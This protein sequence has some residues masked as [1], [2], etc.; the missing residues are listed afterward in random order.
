MM[1]ILAAAGSGRRMG[2]GMNK[3]F[4]LLEGVPVIAHNLRQVSRVPEV[5]RVIVV[6]R[7]DE[8]DEGTSIIKQYQHGYY[9]DLRWEV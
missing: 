1:V 8:V 5:E 4:L 3:A 7:P 2:L 9:P 6:V